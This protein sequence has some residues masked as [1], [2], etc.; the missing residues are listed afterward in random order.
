MIGAKQHW[1]MRIAQLFQVAGDH[2]DL[3]APALVQI[4]SRR[5]QLTPFEISQ[6]TLH[7]VAKCYG[8]IAGRTD[9]VPRQCDDCAILILALN[10]LDQRWTRLYGI[11]ILAPGKAEI[12]PVERR[13]FS[14]Q[15]VSSIG[16]TRDHIWVIVLPGQR[17]LTGNRVQVLQQRSCFRRSMGTYRR[18]GGYFCLRLHHG[19]NHQYYENQ[20]CPF[21]QCLQNRRKRTI[22]LQ[23]V[24]SV[25]ADPQALPSKNFM[26]NSS[27][28]L[29][30]LS[31]SARRIGAMLR[32]RLLHS[33]ERG[34][35]TELIGAT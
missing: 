10:L 18:L 23:A 28:D 5:Q 30:L 33:A 6:V 2:V 27:T 13:I 24:P 21:H 22:L 3:S 35:R 17:V 8:L 4:R 32:V 29:R 19:A 34:K 31:C 12:L 20:D 11:L 9:R 25:C 15:I 16:I 14:G 7:I 1:N 26:D